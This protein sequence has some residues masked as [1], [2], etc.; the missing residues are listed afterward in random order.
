MGPD[1]WDRAESAVATTTLPVA[2]KPVA[3]PAEH[4]GWGLLAEPVVLGL[5]IA[6]APAGACLA[7]AALAGFLARHPLR[8]WLLDRRK[9]VR[10]PRT[11][12]AERF[13]LGYAALAALFA[14]GRHRPGARALL[15]RAPGGGAH[16]T[17]GA[18]LRRARAQ[19]RG[20][21][22]DLGRRRPRR[23]GGGDRSRRRRAPQCRVGRLGAALAPRDHVGALCAGANPPR[24]RADRGPGPGPRRAHGRGSRRPRDSRAPPGR[25]GWRPARSSSCCCAPRGACLPAEAACGRRCWGSR[26]SASACSR[27]RCSRSATASASSRDDHSERPSRRT[28]SSPAA[29]GP[30]AREQV[31]LLREARLGAAHRRVLARRRRASRAG[32]APSP[33]SACGTAPA[34]WLEPA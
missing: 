4:G 19:P 21:A 11:A 32:A 12:L 9:G 25:P 16:R 22:R 28:R 34:R 24:P 13:F 17:P 6:P 15:A 29:A 5:V 23:L 18:E 31:E 1:P 33:R 30:A 14:G 3:I 27:S 26:S 20:R 7:L 10:Y 8:L 2:W